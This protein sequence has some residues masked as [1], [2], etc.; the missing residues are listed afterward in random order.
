ML[1]KWYCNIDFADRVEDKWLKRKRRRRWGKEGVRVYLSG[2]I[3]KDK[4]YMLTFCSG[5][6]HLSCSLWKGISG[7]VLKCSIINAQEYG[8][9]PLSV[10]V[11]S[12]HHQVICSEQ[13]HLMKVF[14]QLSALSVFWW[15]NQLKPMGGFCLPPSL[16]VR[17]H[18]ALHPNVPKWILASVIMNSTLH[19]ATEMTTGSLQACL[20][21]GPPETAGAI[22]RVPVTRGRG[23][24]PSWLPSREASYHLM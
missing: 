1:S 16:P 3:Q 4:W 2:H 9:L 22:W 19:P 15:Q 23:K 8:Q 13:F 17:L 20:V 14:P 7:I 5:L 10:Y 6:N 11:S 24:N 18:L 21:E 12:C